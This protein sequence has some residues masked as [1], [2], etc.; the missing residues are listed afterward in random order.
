MFR[1]VAHGHVEPT[2]TKKTVKPKKPDVE[3]YVCQELQS[4][5]EGVGPAFALSASGAAAGLSWSSVD[6]CHAQGSP[7]FA[8]KR[9]GPTQKASENSLKYQNR[10]DGHPIDEVRHYSLPRS[11]VDPRP[12]STSLLCR[13]S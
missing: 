8:V 1:L 13:G 9:G 7:M 11:R 12:W 4:R 5:A 10:K 6:F 2:T 3:K